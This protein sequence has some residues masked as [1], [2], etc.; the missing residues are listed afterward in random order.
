VRLP[1]GEGDN[2]GRSCS[3]LSPSIVTAPT[4]SSGPRPT[5]KSLSSR[6]LDEVESSA[7]RSPQTA[8]TSGYKRPHPYPTRCHSRYRPG[9]GARQEQLRPQLAAQ[10]SGEI[11]VAT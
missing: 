1:P 6:R 8:T 10:T 7:E 3:W 11:I 5:G 4:P 9:V 2:T